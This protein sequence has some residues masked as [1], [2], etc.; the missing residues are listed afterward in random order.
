MISW[1]KTGV[2]GPPGPQGPPGSQAIP[3]DQYDSQNAWAAE[4]VWVQQ[5]STSTYTWTLSIPSGDRLTVT[6]LTFASGVNGIISALRA[7]PWVHLTRPGNG[8]Q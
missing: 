7:D 6:D 1:N 2:T 4:S 3:T 8:G 5:G